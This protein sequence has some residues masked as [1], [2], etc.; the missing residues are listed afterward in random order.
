MCRENNKNK[1][2]DDSDEITSSSI[3]KDERS[4]GVVSNSKD[5]K[6]SSFDFKMLDSLSPQLQFALLTAFMFLFFG[7]HNLLQE[8]M[9][10]IP[11]FKHGVMLGYMEVLGGE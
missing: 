1:F 10:R 7:V 5:Q 8:A 11:G 9:M 3:S 2:T 6:S 4:N